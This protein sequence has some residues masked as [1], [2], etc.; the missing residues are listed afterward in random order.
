M[1]HTDGANQMVKSEPLIHLPTL[2]NPTMYYISKKKHHPIKSK[3]YNI[4]R[5]Q[6]REMCH[7]SIRAVSFYGLLDNSVKLCFLLG[8]PCFNLLNLVFFTF[9]ILDPQIV[10]LSHH[11]SFP[12]EVDVYGEILVLFTYIKRGK[13]Q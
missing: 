11:I 3:I 1:N 5:F 9:I 4:S 12:T 2:V 13:I 6:S 7:R 8:R 10:W